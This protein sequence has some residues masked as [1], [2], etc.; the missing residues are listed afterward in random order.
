MACFVKTAS[1]CLV[2]LVIGAP[3][4]VHAQFAAPR[5]SPGKPVTAPPHGQPGPETGPSEHR[6]MKKHVKQG[7]S[8]SDRPAAGQEPVMEDQ[9]G[10]GQTPPMQ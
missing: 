7:H 9:Q 1:L 6:H 5:S 3:L 2:V 4:T 10:A 8:P